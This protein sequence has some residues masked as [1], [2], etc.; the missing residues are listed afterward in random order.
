MNIKLARIDDRLIHGQVATVWS[1]EA[2]AGRII[3]VDDEVATDDIRKTLLKQAA[4]PGIKVNTV[5]VEKAIKVYNNPKYANE[6]VFFLFTVPSAPLRMVKGGVP[7]KSVNV[8]GMQFKEGRKQVT[9]AASVTEQE[10]AEFFELE[11]LGV[12]L[13]LRVVAS[14]PKAAF[15]AELRK[16]GFSA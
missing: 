5:N 13:D 4:P 15:G 7:I 2:G 8:G 11:K 14:D 9:K 16:A 1:K 3:V 12:E 10:A 6:D